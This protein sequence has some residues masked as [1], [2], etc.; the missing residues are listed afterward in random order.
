MSTTEIRLQWTPATDEGGVTRYTIA[1]NGTAVASMPTPSYTDQGLS[2]STLYTYTVTAEDAAGNVSA[3]SAAESATTMPL[4][5]TTPPSVALLSPQDKAALSGLITVSATATD[6][7]GV[8][9]VQF[10]LNGAELGPEDT[11]NTYAVSW[12]TTTVA[13]GTYSLIATARDIAN[14]TTTSL[15]VS[16][17]VSNTTSLPLTISNLTLASGKTYVVP[18]AGLQVGGKVYIDRSYTFRTVPASLQG[19]AYI[20]TANNDK[21]ATQAAFLSFT[22][23]QPVTVS[24]AHDVRITPKPAWL[25]TFTDTGKDLVTSDTTLHLFAQSFAAGTITLG[26]NVNAGSGNSMYAVV[27]VPQGGSV[28]PTDSTPPSVPSDL[29]AT[30]MSTTEIRLQWTPATD[31]GGVT[32]YTIVRN[33]TAVASM[34]TPSYTDQGLSPSTLYTYTVTAEDAA[35]NVSAPSAPMS[36]TTMPLP[37]TTPPSVALLSP[38]DKAALSGLITVSATATDNVGVAG[39]QFHL[40]GAELGPE[41]TTNTYAV[42]WDTTTVANGTYSLIATA[43]DIANN[44]TTSLPV[45]VTVSNTTSLPLTISNLTVAS[46]KT[47][48]VPTAGLQ[49]GGKVYIDRSYTFRTVPA[50]LQGAAYIQ[51][52]NN[53]KAATQAAFLSF[54]V[55]QPVTVS[56]AHDVRITPKPAWLATFTDTGKDLVTSDTT[57]HLFAQSFAAGTITLGGNVGGKSMY[58]VVI[59]PQDGSAPPTDSTPPSVPSDLQATPMSTTEIRLQW[60]PATDEGGVTRYTIARNGTAVA[61][62]PTPSY[63]DQGLSPSTLYTYTVTAEDA[64]GNVSAPSAPMSATTM[65][66]PDTTPPS[67]FTASLSWQANSESDVAGYK[68]HYGTSSKTYTVVENVGLTTNP[69]LPS[70][71]V[72]NLSE[73]MTYYFAVTAFDTSGNESG[74]SPEGNKHITQ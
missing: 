73:G 67:D 16:V 12:D 18:T 66:L 8:A 4:P 62:M 35:G 51:T 69:N 3:P 48:V 58:A 40:N 24:V 57:L 52:A 70:Y 26:G 22:V 38:Q 29:Q 6:N 5:D 17:T 1:R 44:T 50:S 33:G 37:D 71:M 2:P 15:P 14:N 19:A 32:R 10:H 63:T 21:A 9:G 56:V 49:V 47:Y 43:R 20:Q 64:A 42:S 30:P 25:A 27:V 54:T 31:E 7:V 72:H 13:N 65:P 53:D 36:A 68:V 55:N 28:P 41:D 60:T 61:S 45:S 46:G 59:Q 11:T 39:V 74:F 34:P 23:N